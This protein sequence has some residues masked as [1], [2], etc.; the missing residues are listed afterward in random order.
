MRWSL[1]TSGHN[2]WMVIYFWS[3]TVLFL[4]WLLMMLC[5]KSRF[6][7][8]LYVFLY[9]SQLLF[10]KCQ[11]VAITR[12]RRL[13]PLDS[14]E[15][16]SALCFHFDNEQTGTMTGRQSSTKSEVK[17]FVLSSRWV[18]LPEIKKKRLADVKLPN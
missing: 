7:T 8:Q 10:Q 17:Y 9:I 5:F 11:K 13:T 15:R 16:L 4:Y 18:R 14:N 2:V 12:Q 3:Y 6:N 1:V